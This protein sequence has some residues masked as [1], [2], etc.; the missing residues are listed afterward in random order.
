MANNLDFAVKASGTAA[1]SSAIS[2]L[3]TKFVGLQA[4]IQIAQKAIQEMQKWVQTS[5]K[6]FRAFEKEIAEVSTI[7]TG[8]T[9]NNIAKLQAGIESLSVSFGKSA[10]DLATGMYDILS[11]AVPVE[12]SLNMLHIATKGATAGLTDVAT[13]VDVFTSILNAYGKT[14]AQMQSISDQLF[15]TVVRGKL[16]FE[17]LASAMGYI[18]PIAANLGVEFKE[19]AAALSTVTRQGQHVDMATRGLALGIQNIADITPKA[20][21]AAKKY[22]V[23]L[24]S[25][26]LRVFGLQHVLE[27]LNRAMD[28][29]GTK[30]LPEM[31]S[32]MRSLR[33]FMALAGDEGVLGYK[34]D[35]DKL[36]NSA[37]RTEEAMSKMMNVTKKQAELLDQAMQD[38]NRS[39]GK[40]WQSV[41]IWW[42]KTQLWW[43]TLLSGGDANKAVSDFESNVAGYR[44]AF[45][46]MVKAEDKYRNRK[47]FSEILEQDIGMDKIKQNIPI[48]EIKEYYRL[49]NL[50]DEKAPKATKLTIAAQELELIKDEWKNL[51]SYATESEM[52]KVYNEA[53]RLAK[54]YGEYEGDG[55]FGLHD[56]NKAISSVRGEN[57]KLIA[58]IQSLRAQQEPLESDLNYIEEGFDSL[59]EKIENTEMNLYELQ[60]AIDSL[61]T[62]TEKPFKNLLDETIF[63]T[64]GQEKA[65]LG[66]D[67]ITSRFNKYTGMAIKY[68]DDLDKLEKSFDDISGLDWFDEDI[69]EQVSQGYSSSS[70]GLKQ[71]VEDLHSFSEEE[72]TAE[73]SL[74]QFNKAL[75][76]QRL[77]IEKNNLEIMKLQLKEMSKRHG[78]SRRDQRTMKKLRIENLEH[79]I[80]IKEK[81]IDIEEEGVKESISNQQNKYDELKSIYDEYV[82][83]LELKSF[84]IQDI[85]NTEYNDLVT[86]IQNS[87]D[88]LEEYSQKF[89]EEKDKW[90][91]YIEDYTT[92]LEE[93]AVESENDELMRDILGYDGIQ[94][95][96][97]ALDAVKKRAAETEKHLGETTKY[98]TNTT[99]TGTTTTNLKTIGNPALD[100]IRKTTPGM[101]NLLKNMGKQRGSY[102]IPQTGLYTL[103]RGEQVKPASNNNKTGNGN[104]NIHVDPISVNA[105]VNNSSDIEDIG[106]KIGQAIASEFISGVTSEYEVG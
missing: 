101:H 29:H 25:T 61:R 78:L 58:D 56:L 26:A 23:D 20:A 33:V 66:I 57:D 2:G 8:D 4:G 62:A 77:E 47:P 64:M 46:S 32:N 106:N 97:D 81:Q 104:I 17:D 48:K 21:E 103:H 30:V 69:W 41:D 82:D 45:L 96:L 72:T 65:V 98:T 59:A 63:G 40:A 92:A 6:E 42:K 95:V 76:E 73:K 68:G 16:R 85:R 94:D 80:E 37:G 53:E 3:A 55:A 83:R 36:N 38:L 18:V 91:G 84:E 10:H 12:D 34:E 5:I 44:K 87:K 1:T 39:I 90:E 102:Y 86:N 89:L 50:I 27:D 9:Y 99:D 105:T 74:K 67:M 31:I 51:G 79:N 54:K 100:F 75:E 52:S 93:L 24:S 28:E 49:Q 22:G 71:L 15:Q 88:R 35:L 19:V 13:S 70:E 7:L 11:A 60:S 43:G 14:V